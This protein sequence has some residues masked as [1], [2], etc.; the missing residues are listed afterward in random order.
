MYI[1]IDISPY[2]IKESRIYYV[3]VKKDDNQFPAMCID[4]DSHI[5]GAKLET[6]LDK[7]AT[8]GVHN[9]QIGKYSSL[10]EGIVLLMDVDKDYKQ[11]CMGS[12]AWR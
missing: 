6:S 7:H 1:D 11:V 12:I 3:D 4:K 2:D 8:D 9:F 5:V 10:A